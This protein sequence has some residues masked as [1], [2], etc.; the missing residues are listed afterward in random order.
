MSNIPIR[1]SVPLGVKGT[2]VKKVP[3]STWPNLCA[4]LSR[5][6][7]DLIWTIVWWILRGSRWEMFCSAILQ[8]V[9]SAWILFEK[10]QGCHSQLQV[11]WRLVTFWLFCK[12]PY[13]EKGSK[14][15]SVNLYYAWP[16]A[17]GSKITGFSMLFITRKPS[18][19]SDPCLSHWW[20]ELWW[21]DFPRP[22]KP[23]WRGWGY[24]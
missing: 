18:H 5:K 2:D 22:S 20:W 15:W 7:M 6:R 13:V 3:L 4:V 19:C 1:G 10:Q 12:D 9:I 11:T 17:K 21:F 8:F 23:H 14:E 16:I 24:M